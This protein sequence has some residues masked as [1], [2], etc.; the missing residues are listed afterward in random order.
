M[1]SDR[2]YTENYVGYS[3]SLINIIL[4]V[5]VSIR[6]QP[7][8]ISTKTMCSALCRWHCLSNTVPTM[9]KTVSQ[10]EF[11]RIDNSRNMETV[12]GT[13]EYETKMNQKKNVLNNLL[14]KLLSLFRNI[15]VGCI[16]N[17]NVL[18]YICYLHI[19]YVLWEFYDYGIL[20]KYSHFMKNFS[21]WRDNKKQQE[22]NFGISN[23]FSA[24]FLDL[25]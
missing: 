12:A 7:S 25:F 1:Y 18:L 10:Q 3:N 21:V 6:T 11:H 14:R 13:R 20:F 9:A 16:K 22:K 8:K 17:R 5:S 23:L 2:K 19:L 15:F 4:I 24:I